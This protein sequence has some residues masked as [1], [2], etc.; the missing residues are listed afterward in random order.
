MRQPTRAALMA[1]VN[2]LE[3]L[4]GRSRDENANLCEAF[5]TA[6]QNLR[7]ANG[8]L[9]IIQQDNARGVQSR[10]ELRKELDVVYQRNRDL[11]DR[12]Q[13][14]ERELEETKDQLESAMQQIEV[15]ENQAALTAAEAK[16]ELKGA[17]NV[18]REMLI[19]AEAYSA[20]DSVADH[21]GGLGN[22]PDGRAIR[23]P[24]GLMELIARSAGR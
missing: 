5:T 22:A 20:A 12:F 23:V 21:F 16:G 6:S 19:K 15:V 4:L 9:E 14:T 11:S 2:E 8:R 13:Q 10:L 24:A 17:A 1:R 3:V 7:Q 18:W